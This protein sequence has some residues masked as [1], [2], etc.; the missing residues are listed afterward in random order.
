MFKRRLALAY[1]TKN[2]DYLTD[3]LDREGITS[4]VTLQL[5]KSTRF[6]V[7][8]DTDF[9]VLGARIGILDIAI[10]AGFSDFSFLAAQGE[11]AVGQ[12]DT[13]VT[14][15]LSRRPPLGEQ[16]TAFIE[17]ID[18]LVAELRLLASYIRDV[19]AAHM[20]RTECKGMIEKLAYRLEY[21]VRT[22]A[23]RKKGVFGGGGGGTGSSNVFRNFMSKQQGC[24]A[25]GTA[26]SELK[27]KDEM[28]G[29]R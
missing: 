1:F 18:G 8:E 29:A 28:F 4:T 19:G 23:K 15:G 11:E 16:E 20:R 21:G 12:A 3:K 26:E 14:K 9:A 7:R 10:G 27:A 6:K 13:A 2:K 25:E 17:A 24:G 22:R 5:Q